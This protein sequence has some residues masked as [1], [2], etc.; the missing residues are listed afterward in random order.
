MP[1]DPHKSVRQKVRVIFTELA[2]ERWAYLQGGG[3]A[4]TEMV[5]ALSSGKQSEVAAEVA[6]H[7]WDW[8]E[9]AAFVVA[10]HLFPERFTQKE[11]E[12]GV[13]LFLCHAPA[14]IIA[15]ARLTGS[16][17]EDIFLEDD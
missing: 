2:G 9:D 5:R 6:F 11:I 8:S 1:F 13:G 15:A 3:K 12:A 14:H 4:Q 17:T 10:L 7:M 16:S